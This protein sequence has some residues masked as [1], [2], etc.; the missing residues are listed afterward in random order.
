M[1]TIQQKLKENNLKHQK[2]VKKIMIK[3]LNKQKKQYKKI[4]DTIHLMSK[5][6]AIKELVEELRTIT[7]SNQNQEIVFFKTWLQ[8]KFK[9][10]K[11]ANYV[12]NRYITEQVLDR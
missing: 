12:Y 6:V 10:Y 4:P 11:K 7:I 3:W 8:I 2:R 1:K 5:C 9:Q